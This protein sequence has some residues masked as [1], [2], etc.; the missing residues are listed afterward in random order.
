MMKKFLLLSLMALILIFPA[1]THADVWGVRALTDENEIIKIDPFTGT[2]TTTYAAPN[3]VLN[4]T[5]IG[6]AGWSDQLFYTT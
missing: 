3:F 2:V 1:V 6:L 4:N 5:E